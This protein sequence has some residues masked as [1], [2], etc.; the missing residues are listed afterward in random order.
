[1][2]SLKEAII[3]AAERRTYQKTPVDP[4][5]PIGE[6]YCDNPR[7]MVRSVQADYRPT[8][9]HP[10]PAM[11]CPSCRHRLRFVAY[12]GDELDLG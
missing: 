10:P 9:T 1:M 3:V 8:A 2:C 12:V 11:Q 5:N 4:N 6:W 7:C